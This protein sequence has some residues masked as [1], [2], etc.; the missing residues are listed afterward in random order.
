MGQVR[1]RPQALDLRNLGPTRSSGSNPQWQQ[2]QQQQRPGMPGQPAPAQQQQAGPQ[3]PQQQQQ[4]VATDTTTTGGAS[5]AAPAAPASGASSPSSS[6]CRGVMGFMDLSGI[7]KAAAA[8]A[9]PASAGAGG[10]EDGAAAGAGKGSTQHASPFEAAV[11]AASEAARAAGG[12]ENG[13]ASGGEPPGIQ[14]PVDPNSTAGTTVGTG[15]VP[16]TA[17]GELPWVHVGEEGYIC[18]NRHV[19]HTCI[20]LPVDASGQ[21]STAGATVGT[22][23]VPATAGGELLWAHGCVPHTY[24]CTAALGGRGRGKLRKSTGALLTAVCHSSR[25]QQCRVV[26]KH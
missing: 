3:P 24:G 15:S 17:G 19:R 21:T 14:L 4:A 9:D 25:H 18:T 8:V 6:S 1:P 13:G 20:Q 2:Q 16:A 7:K 23:S 22:G 11:A 5:P 26:S 12:G 10:A